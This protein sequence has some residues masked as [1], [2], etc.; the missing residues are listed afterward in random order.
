MI[1][2]VVPHFSHVNSYIYERLDK[3]TW[4]VR[5]ILPE[6]EGDILIYKATITIW[7]NRYEQIVQTIY[8]ATVTI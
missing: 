2:L 7:S 6:F 8:K 1:Y 4:Q 3:Y 5:S